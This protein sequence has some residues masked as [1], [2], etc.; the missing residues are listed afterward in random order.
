MCVLCIIKSGQP[1]PSKTDLWVMHLANPHGMG[2][3]SKSI[4]YKFYL[5]FNVKN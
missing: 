4:H 1:L 5:C 2:F 3:A